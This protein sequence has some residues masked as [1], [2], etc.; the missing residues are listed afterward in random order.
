MKCEQKQ[1]FVIFK[2]NKLQKKRNNS[3]CLKEFLLMDFQV[4]V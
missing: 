3:N 2:Q 4:Q 1:I